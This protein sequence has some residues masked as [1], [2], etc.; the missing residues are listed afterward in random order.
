MGC[1]WSWHWQWGSILWE[2]VEGHDFG[3]SPLLPFLCLPLLPFLAVPQKSFL[4]PAQI[5]PEEAI[6]VES[7][8][9]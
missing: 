5:P 4:V 9:P 8:H 2:L 1:R 7:A 3:V 6:A